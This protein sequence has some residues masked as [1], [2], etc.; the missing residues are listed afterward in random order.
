MTL[1]CGMEFIYEGGFQNILKALSCNQT[2][3]ENKWAVDCLWVEGST[4]E[5]YQEMN[6]QTYAGSELLS[7]FSC[8][9]E[10]FVYFARIREYAT[11]SDI[12][13]ISAFE[14]FLKSRCTMIILVM[15][16]CF[17]EIYAKSEEELLSIKSN[18]ASLF[19]IDAKII[20]MNKITRVELT[21]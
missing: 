6:N 13:H 15:D 11:S 4:G 7:Q 19:S 14:D 1:I 10:S 20:P 21:V 16:S 5:S 17:C 2:F 18:L 8:L 3:S 12:D 9:D